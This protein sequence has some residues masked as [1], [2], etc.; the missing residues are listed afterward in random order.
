MEKKYS[1]ANNIIFCLFIAAFVCGTVNYLNGNYLFYI[2][3]EIF[4][5]VA[6]SATFIKWAK[7]KPWLEVVNG[8][9]FSVAAILWPIGSFGGR[10]TLVLC[11]F[12]LCVAG[13]LL[14]IA[15]GG[16]KRIESTESKPKEDTKCQ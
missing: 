11:S 8:N 4:W 6:I 15:R 5:V 12:Y 13:G 7:N 16:F 14:Y 2:F 9:F 3:A 1:L 10:L